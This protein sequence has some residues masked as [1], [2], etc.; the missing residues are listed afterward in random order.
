MTA[1][2]IGRESVVYDELTINERQ[3]RD[4]EFGQLLNEVRV[5]CLSDKTV[6]LLHK[7]VMKCTAVEEFQ[8]LLGQ[9]F[10]SVCLFP[11]RKSCDQFNAE[12]LSKVGSQIVHMPCIEEFDET[13]GKVKWTKMA[14]SALEKLNKDCN[15]TAGLEPELKLAVGVRVMLR[16]NLD[17]R[18]G[19][20]N[21]ALGTVS[22]IGIQVTFD[23]IQHCSLK[24]NVCIVNFKYYTVSMCT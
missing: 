19:L 1:V 23:H 13:A 12:M 17:T 15:M 2:N 11:T 20:V 24:L 14:S 7:A 4:P 22:A 21:G 8:E 3:K 10:S 9:G 5:N 18:Q 16:R 6:A